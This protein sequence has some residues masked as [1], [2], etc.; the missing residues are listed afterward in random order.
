MDVRTI[1][2]THLNNSSVHFL[3]SGK[4][5]SCFYK[6]KKKEKESFVIFILLEAWNEL[7]RKSERRTVFTTDAYILH[8]LQSSEFSLVQQ[9]FGSLHACENRK[10]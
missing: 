9:I 4:E 2:R 7:K 10:T 1:S 6:T 8:S 3:I 5:T